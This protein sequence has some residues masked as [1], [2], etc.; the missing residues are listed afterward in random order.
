MF[1]SGHLLRSSVS[2]IGLTLLTAGAAV[3]QQVAAA[4]PANQSV[5]PPVDQT[6]V[7]DD[8]DTDSVVVTAR[9]R[10]EVLQNIPVSGTVVT[11]EE[12]LDGN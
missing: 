6:G 11:E 5:E 2:W 4:Q 3:A 12:I 7:A 1:R 9:R 10:D 8:D